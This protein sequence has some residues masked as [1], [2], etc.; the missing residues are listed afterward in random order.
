MTEF[1]HFRHGHVR[2]FA[3]RS[4]RDEGG[5]HPTLGGGVAR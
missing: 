5:S 2:V 1:L 3:V 4:K